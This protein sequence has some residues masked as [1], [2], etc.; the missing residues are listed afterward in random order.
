MEYSIDWGLQAA[1][2]LGS[3][4]GSRGRHGR[5]RSR[6]CCLPCRPNPPTRSCTSPDL[7]IPKWTPA[8]A[9]MP[10]MIVV[11]SDRPHHLVS[12]T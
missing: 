11:H 3:K 4:Q 10:V 12:A 7:P 2:E 8:A 6:G 9:D 1:L 5:I